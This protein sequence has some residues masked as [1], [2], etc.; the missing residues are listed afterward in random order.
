MFGTFRMPEHKL[1]GDYG[2][3]DQSVRPESAG[4]CLSVPPLAKSKLYSDR[5]S[6][7]S[8]TLAMRPL[9]KTLLMLCAMVPRGAGRRQI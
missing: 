2:V 7:R 5:Y 8:T 4:N 9:Q 3:D 1:P 6:F